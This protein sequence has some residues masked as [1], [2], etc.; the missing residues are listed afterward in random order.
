MTDTPRTLRTSVVL[1]PL[2]IWLLIQLAA[3]A[4]AASGVPL[5]ANFPRPPQSL[6]VHE[7]LVAQFVGSA[8]FFPALFR[9][10]WRGWLAIVLSAA[11]MLMLAA[12]L[13]R[14]PLSRV[15]MLWVHVTAWVTMLALWRAVALRRDESPKAEGWPSLGFLGVLTALATLLSAGG[16]LIWYLHSEFQP[17][18][19]LAILRLF[20]L[21]ALLH[22]LTAPGGPTLSP[23]LS[24]VTL[25]AAA[26]VILAV[27]S[28]RRR[29]NGQ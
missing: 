6:A 16:L 12:W 4:L 21:P 20:P 8:M 28:S 26:L 1:V 27:K 22:S 23:L 17:D 19:D 11:P 18:R 3:V 14:T 5:S 29:A 2:I 24:T 13:A 9:G 7:M 10:G 25:S 15:P